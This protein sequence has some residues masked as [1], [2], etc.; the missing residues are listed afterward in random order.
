[1]KASSSHAAKGI[2]LLASVVVLAGCNQSG[3]NDNSQ[4]TGQPTSVVTKSSTATPSSESELAS[5][6]SS[7]AIVESDEQDADSDGKL[8]FSRENLR[9]VAPTILRHG[10]IKTTRPRFLHLRRENGILISP[11][12]LKMSRVRRCPGQS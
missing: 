4:A 11:L 2:A 6:D 3:D 8:P 1:M 7:S 12:S 5:A 10:S 9:R